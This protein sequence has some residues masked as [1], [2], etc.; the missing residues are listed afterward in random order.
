[1]AFLPYPKGTGVSCHK[2]MKNLDRLPEIIQGGMGIGV[3]DWRLAKAV[4]E[5]GYMGVVSGTAIDSVMVRR[6]QLGDADGSIRRALSN[7]PWKDMAQRVLDEYFIPGGKPADKP[8]KL[9]PMLSLQMKRENIELLIISNFAEVFLAKEG[10]NN[11]VGINYLEKIQLPTL[12]SLFGAMLAGIDFVLMGGGIPLAIPGILDGLSCLEPVEIKLHVEDNPQYLNYSNHFDPKEFCSGNLPRLTRPGFL[13]IISSDIVAKNIIRRATG[14]VDGFIVE[15]HTAG[16]HNAP[17]RKTDKSKTHSFLQFSPKDTP[18]IEKIR[19]MNLPFWLAGGYASPMKLKEALAQGA[20][21][22]QVGTI[23]A[24]CRESGMAA[25][26]KQEVL[27]QYMNGKLEVRTDFQASP[28]GY[29]FKLISLRS[30]KITSMDNKKDRK[31]ICDMGYLRQFYCND[32]SEI[33]YRCPGEPVKNFLAKG[34]V[35]EKTVGK[36]CLCNG[37]LATVGLGQI[38]QDGPE[39]PLITSG[40][41]F[42]FISDIIKKSGRNYCA[43]DVTDYLKREV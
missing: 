4:S 34:G 10:H 24:Y 19:E 29:P 1:M 31:R 35:L 41:D 36:Q 7:F 18:D 39:S 22:I 27:N 3:S 11:P 32:N 28:T 40:E 6:L 16:G 17:P 25:E 12:P 30:D 43:K 2:F 33:A 23:F 14:K 26:I 21:G 8:F 38:R 15:N 20:S 5:Q 9:L 42:S 37:L 13:A